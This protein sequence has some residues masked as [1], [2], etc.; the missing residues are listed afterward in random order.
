MM[1]LSLFHLVLKLLQLL[2]QSNLAV[3]IDVD[4]NNNNTKDNDDDDDDNE[5]DDGDDKED[6][7]KMMIVLMRALKNEL[8]TIIVYQGIEDFVT[9]NVQKRK[10]KPG[11]V[12]KSPLLNEFGSSIKRII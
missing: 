1:I 9:P 6:S 4:V 8:K 10:I 11:Y 5:D 3:V 12:L 7:K 2:P